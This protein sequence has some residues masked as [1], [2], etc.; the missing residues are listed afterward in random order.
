MLELLNASR[1][2]VLLGSTPTSQ[3]DEQSH[4]DQYLCAW[5]CSLRP[6]RAMQPRTAGRRSQPTPQ[7]PAARR[8]YG[9]IGRWT[10]ITH[11]DTD[12]MNRQRNQL[13][14]VSL[15]PITLVSSAPSYAAA[16]SRSV[17][18]FGP[19]DSQPSTTTLASSQRTAPCLASPLP[20]LPPF[21]LPLLSPPPRS[22]SG[23]CCAVPHA[24]T[25]GLAKELAVQDTPR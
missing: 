2:S 21:L 19:I 8:R 5:Q 24:S 20:F 22:I 7:P 1:K 10:A 13:Y 14:S 18:K 15:R 12:S 25:R 23:D 9:R 11:I 3:C 16:G 17:V 6:A 4:A